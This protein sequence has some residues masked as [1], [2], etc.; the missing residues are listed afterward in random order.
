MF[1]EELSTV[2]KACAVD[3]AF[4]EVASLERLK[5]MTL[6]SIA[7]NLF[8]RDGD[9]SVVLDILALKLQEK[10]HLTDIV[11]THFNGEYMVNNLLYCWKTWEKKDGW[12]GM[13]HCS[14]KQYQHFVETQEMQQLL[15]S[16]ESIWKE[17]LIRLLLQAETI[18][19]SI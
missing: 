19:Y 1:Y 17:P 10:Y 12:D 5:E 18:L 8:D 7:L 11:I 9:T 15:T 16:G 14:E 3:V 13:V 2:E 6:S 4:A